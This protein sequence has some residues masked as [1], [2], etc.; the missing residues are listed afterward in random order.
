MEL[1][2]QINQQNELI[3]PEGEVI[4][5]PENNN[6]ANQFIE[7][8]TIAVSQE[9]LKNDTIIPV[10]SKDNETTISHPQFIETAERAVSK[11]FPNFRATSP[12]I[13][14]SHIIKGRIP[15][16]IGKPAKEL[17]DHEKTIFYERMMFLIEI[18]AITQNVNGNELMLNIGGVRA[19]NKENLYSKKT[20]EKFKVF[21]GFKNMVCTNMCISTDGFKNEIRVSNVQELQDSME[22]L[23]YN[24]DQEKHLGNLERMSKFELGAEQVAHLIGK[25]KLYQYLNSKDKKLLFPIPF[26]DTQINTIAKNYYSDANFRCDVAGNI[27][28]WQ[29]YNLMTEATKSS[30]IDS[31]LN[32]NSQA[33][34]LCQYLTNKLQNKEKD[35][36]LI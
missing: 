9:H 28:L 20:I 31:F 14:V 29:L 10:F 32:R 17:L 1:F 13:R 36:L 11:V 21:I 7:A 12:A 4:S 26:N 15:S 16:A 23:F 6:K 30:Y 3:I 34:E 22:L 19:Y 25:M 8:N 5:I 2:Q 24:Y 35:W 33:Y 18:P 27:N